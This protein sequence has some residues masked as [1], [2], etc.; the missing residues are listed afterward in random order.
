ML[1]LK[2][3]IATL[4]YGFQTPPPLPSLPSSIN[5]YP[6]NPVLNKTRCRYILHDMGHLWGGLTQ[7]GG[8][9]NA[10]TSCSENACII[11][12]SRGGGAKLMLGV[13][14]LS[15]LKLKLLIKII[16]IF[17]LNEKMF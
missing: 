10:L 3:K 2:C 12:C 8:V 16:N 5:F 17:K 11:F 13:Q 1:R 9:Y 7:R 15:P 4:S 6:L 14:L